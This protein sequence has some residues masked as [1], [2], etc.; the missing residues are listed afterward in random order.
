MPA[1][2]H[3]EFERYLRCGRLEEGFLRVVCSGCRHEHLVAFSCKCRGFCPSCGA[4]RMVETAAGLVEHVLPH[5]PVAAPA[6]PA[7][8]AFVHPCTSRPV[9]AVIPLAAAPA[10]CRATGFVDTRARGGDSGAV[11]GGEAS[12]RAPRRDRCRDRRG[13]V[14]LTAMDGGNAEGLQEQ[15][16]PALRLRTQPEH[17]PASAGARRRLYIRRRATTVP[18]RPSADQRRD[19]APA[20]C[21]DPARRSDL[22]GRSRH[23]ASR[24]IRT[25]LYVTRRGAG[26]RPR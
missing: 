4:R 26:G 21:A 23:P 19:R 2:V 14:H 17:P 3:E 12:C 7:L 9:G 18:S 5:V 8:A 20:R 15:S 16:L 24:G 10:L 22:D 6:H 1:F 11:D 13:D 25:S